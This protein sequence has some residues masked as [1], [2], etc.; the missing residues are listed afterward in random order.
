M[1]HLIGLTYSIIAAIFSAFFMYLAIQKKNERIFIISLILLLVSWS[2]M[3]W[4]L[5]ILGHDMFKL[6][7]E[8]IVPLAA[9]F[10]VQTL[11]VIYLSEKTFKRRDWVF[12]V[13]AIAAVSA[14]AYFC[15]DCI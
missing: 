7:V 12:F 3:E 8:P 4:A 2:G 10:L 9:F 5:W 13:S 11:I 15:M 1:I 6:V 14:I